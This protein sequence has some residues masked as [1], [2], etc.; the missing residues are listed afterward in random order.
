MPLAAEALKNEGNR[1]LGAG[2]VEAAIAAYRAAL[3]L[4]PDY[5]PAL[6]NLALILKQ[7]GG[8]CEAEACLRRAIEVAPNDAELHNN[9]AVLLH[10]AGRLDEA[11]RSY[12]EALRIDPA[13]GFANSNYGGLLS[14]TG[15]R[16][17]A[18][19]YCR[20][21]TAAVPDSVAAWATL[22]KV[23]FD[24]GQVDAA[25]PVLERAARMPGAGSEQMS[26]WLYALLYLPGNAGGGEW[27]AYREFDRDYVL[28]RRT[29]GFRTAAPAA[30]GRLRLGYLS[31]AIRSHATCFFIGGVFAHHDRSQ[32]EVFLYDTA[33]ARDDVNARL[34]A[35]V[36][37][38]IDCAHLAD[39][40]LA[41]R[42]RADR[43]DLLIDLDGHIGHNAQLALAWQP[44]PRQ[45]GWLGYPHSTG[46]SAIDY[47]L[48]DRHIAGPEHAEPHSERLV[49]MPDFY[50]VFDPGP[51]PPVSSLPAARNGFVT[52]GSFNA[53][54]K[55]N[56]AVL[57]AWAAVL[58]AVPDSRLLLAS[59]PGPDFERRVLALFAAAGIAAARVR[60]AAS[61]PH[62]EFLALH[63]EADVAL[64]PFPVNG[65]TTSLFGLWMGLPLLTVAGQ[66]HRARVGLSLME[67][68]GMGEWIAAS[69][70]ALA[71][72]ARLRCVDIGRLAE[73][74]AG[75]RERV[76]Q[77][78][79]CDAGRFTRVFEQQLRRLCDAPVS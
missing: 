11:L 41:E 75:L 40:A 10:E 29:S 43:L 64:D 3:D 28:P 17:S 66:S 39:R 1:L 20:R 56:H 44:A 38:P 69:P 63:A 16:E 27:S 77:S 24:A 47:W 6:N 65:T 68:L 48:T 71:D 25:L 31:G 14:Q 45:L 51:A 4:D 78:P 79:L 26:A 61:C 70:E 35:L 30:A 12:G 59:S 57:Q 23:L 2:Q 72:C 53:P 76:R 9:L 19:D 54:N 73:L 52:F 36:E 22:G 55:L 49:P 33:Q 60:F 32:V 7:A 8:R 15:Q 50:M 62:D 34:S 67:N 46:S 13:D 18:I 58:Q 42:I 5:V 37:H 21:A 74:R